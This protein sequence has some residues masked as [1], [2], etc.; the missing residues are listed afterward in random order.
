LICPRPGCAVAK[1]HLH[2]SELETVRYWRDDEDATVE[3]LLTR[4]R[5][6]LGDDP[7]VLDRIAAGHALAS[8]MERGG[9]YADVETSEGW[10]FVF[11]GDF[12]IEQPHSQEAE[13]ELIVDTAHGPIALVGHSDMVTAPAVRDQK[14]TTRFDAERYIDSLQWRSYLLMFDRREFV[15]DVFEGPR[16]DRTVTIRDHHKLTFY[17]YPDM[18]RDVERAV[19]DAAAIVAR[20]MPERFGHA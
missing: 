18:R 13:G 8:L 20:H 14:L 4:L 9:P 16:K 1:P 6:G 19:R 10:R 17:A 11:A 5:G 12:T 2:A 7:E 15:Y 3:D